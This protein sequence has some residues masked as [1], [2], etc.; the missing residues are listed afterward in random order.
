MCKASGTWIKSCARSYVSVVLSLSF[1]AAAKKT[2]FT[3]VFGFPRELTLMSFRM[4]CIG[5]PKSGDNPL[6]FNPENFS[7]EA[8]EKRDPYSFL[9]FG[10]GPRQCIGMRLALMEI[11]LGLMKIMQAIQV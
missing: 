6:E 5:T 3:K 9:P 8:K 10:T 7:S 11:K 2:L 4:C 1:D